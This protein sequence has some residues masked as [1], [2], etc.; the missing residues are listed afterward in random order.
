M[1]EKGLKLYIVP[2]LINCR[3]A[4]NRFTFTAKVIMIIKYPI[5]NLI[6]MF[7]RLIVFPKNI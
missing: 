5:K 3:V 2:S 1:G 6:R 7:I 4:K